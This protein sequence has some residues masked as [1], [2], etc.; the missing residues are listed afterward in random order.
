VTHGVNILALTGISPAESEIV[1][2]RPGNN[3]KF[4]VL[5]HGTPQR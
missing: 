5:G 4:T 3:G 1:A 2:V